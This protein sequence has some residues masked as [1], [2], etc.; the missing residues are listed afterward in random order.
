MDFMEIKDLRQKTSEELESLLSGKRKSFW[1]FRISVSGG[2]SRNVK[3]GK[4][5]RKE[6]ARIMTILSEKKK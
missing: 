4:N 1:D 5:L 6:I 3:E 2:K